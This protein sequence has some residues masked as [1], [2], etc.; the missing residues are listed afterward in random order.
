ME[1]DHGGEIVSIYS[2]LGATGIAVKEGDLI[3]SGDLIGVVGDTS[4]SELADEP[5]LHFGVKVSGVSV[6]PLDYISEDSKSASL[7]MTEV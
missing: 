5:H 6:N 1:I 4:L 3:E 2:N 7:G